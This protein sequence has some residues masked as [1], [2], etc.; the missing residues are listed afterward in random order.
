MVASGNSF[1]IPVVPEP[2]DEDA[3][4][5]YWST[6][7]KDALSQVSVALSDHDTAIYRTAYGSITVNDAGTPQTGIDTTPVKITGFDTNGPSLRCTPDHTTD[8]IAVGLA[9]TY[10]VSFQLSFSGSGAATFNVHAYVNG[11]TTNIGFHRKMGS[12]GDTG[13]ASA[14]GLVTLDAGAVITLYGAAD[15]SGKSATLIDAQLVVIL[16]A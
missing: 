1:V 2:V 6:T 10:L 14:V 9:G 16:L 4:S 7:V 13:S 8:Q 5:Y 3:D 11:A 12:T 15:A